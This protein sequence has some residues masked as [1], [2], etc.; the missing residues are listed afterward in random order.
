MNV[1]GVNQRIVFNCKLKMQTETADDVF[2][3][4]IAA[5]AFYPCCKY[6]G[7]AQVL[8]EESASYVLNL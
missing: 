1:A 3:K 5:L 7:F 8:L 6:S 4:F 2:D